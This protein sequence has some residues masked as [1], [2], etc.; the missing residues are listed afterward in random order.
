MSRA[1]RER[2]GR[3]MLEEGRV[4]GLEISLRSRAGPPRVLRLWSELMP[5][6]DGRRMVTMAEDV[7]EQVAAEAARLELH[8]RLEKVAARVPGVMFQLRREVTGAMTLPYVSAQ[9][10]S[11]FGAEPGE[12]AADARRLLARFHPEDAPKVSAALERSAATSSP[13]KFEARLAGGGPGERWVLASALPG[14]EADGGVSWTGF[15]ADITDQKRAEA[16]LQ[17]SQDRFQ[18]ALEAT[19]DAVWDWDRV[20][21]PWAS[22]NYGRMLGYGPGELEANSP[23]WQALIHPDDVGAVMTAIRGCFADGG[24]DHYDLQY[25]M[26]ARSGEWKYVM[27]R[28]KVVSRDAAGRATRVVGTHVDVTDRARLQVEAAQKDRLANLGLLAAG[29]AHEVNNP[30]SWVLSNLE[31]VAGAMQRLAQVTALAEALLARAGVDPG[32]LA[33][34]D[35]AFSELTATAQA[36]LEGTQR[37]RDLSRALGAFVRVDDAPEELVD[38]NQ[39][40]QTA[41]TMATNELRFRA[42]LVNALQPVPPVRAV[43][44]KVAQVFLNLLVHAAHSIPEGRVDEHLVTLRTWERDGSVFAE[45]RDTGRPL[46]PEQAERLLEPDLTPTRGGGTGLGLTIAKDLVKDLRGDVRV[47][48]EEGKGTRVV[49]RLP[50]AAPEPN[51]MPK[52]MPEPPPPVS[53]AVGKGRVLVV[54]DEPAIRR[55]LQRV[56]KEHE[57]VQAGNGREAKRLLEQD[58]A[59]DV[60]LCDVSMPELSGP[61]LHA[62]LRTFSPPLAGRFVFLTGGAFS[63]AV[64]A[65]IEQSGAGQVSKPFDGAKLKALVA[66]RV[67]RARR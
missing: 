39:A 40:L 46:S 47:T 30:L 52:P 6:D 53:G 12:V 18:L 67:A 38:V 50:A 63:D 25:R 23:A 48:S 29:V 62:W 9:L 32:P 7:T 65:A 55:S 11:L 19:S 36:A 31:L 17:A 21:G 4:A 33:P 34:P 28:G 16:A 1:D 26:R 41:A 51:P 59:F 24:Q 27:G 22:P 58:Q 66:E 3:T 54:D 13:L 45:V 60:I 42:R 5:E 2:L 15:I 10:R 8:R 61:E 44:G 64:S 35:G 49:V 56:L 57:V 43:M 20:R 14:R 37:L